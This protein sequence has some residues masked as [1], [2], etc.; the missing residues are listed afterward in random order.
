MGLFALIAASLVQL[1]GLSS[2]GHFE[3][4]HEETKSNEIT[5]NNNSS[6][7]DIDRNESFVLKL[8]ITEDII[9]SSNEN[10]IQSIPEKIAKKVSF[11]VLESGIMVHSLIIGLTLGVTP[12][13]TF[14]TLL[15]AICFHQLFEGVALAVLLHGTG[16]QWRTKLALGLLYPL[17]TPIGMAIGVGIRNSF[18]ENSQTAIL[19]QGIFDS[20]SAGSLIYSTYTE[21]MSLEISHSTIFKSYS[22]KFKTGCLFSLYLGAAVMAIIAMWA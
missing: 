7:D 14:S 8:P 12:D 10:Y 9:V 11:V 20:L 2:H 17:V 13:A 5:T 3:R 6:I 15:V 1:I 21:L 16:F 18:E 19:V 22:L 4:K